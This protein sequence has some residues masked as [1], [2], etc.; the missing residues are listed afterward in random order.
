MSKIVPL[1]LLL[2][3][4]ASCSENQEEQKKKVPPFE[5][6]NI[7]VSEKMKLAMNPDYLDQIGISKTAQPFLQEYYK[8][9]NYQ[10]RWIDE[11]ALTANGVKMKNLMDSAI[12]IGIPDGRAFKLNI[13]NYIQEELFITASLSRSVS[14]LQN[15]MID[16][17][18]TTAK[19]K[20]FAAAN[21]FDKITNFDFSKDLKH[22]FIQYG[23]NDSTYI[24]LAKG[25][26][27]IADTLPID[28]TRFEIKPYKID[29]ARSFNMMREALVS[30]GYLA[31]SVTDSLGIVDRLKRFQ[32]DNALDTDGK[33]GSNTC[34][35]LNESTYDKMERIILVMDKI[36]SKAPYPKKYLRINIPEYK[37]RYFEDDTLRT[38]HNIVVGKYENQTPELRSSLRRI[39]VYPNWNVPYSISTREILPAVK[40]SV[41][42]LA[43]HDYKVYRGNKEVDPH[44]VNWKQYGINS[45][46]FRIVQ[47]PGPKNSLGIIKFDFHNEHSVYFHD[48]PAKSLFSLPVRAFSHGCMRTHRPVALA[49]T[50]LHY[51]SLSP[52]RFN[53]FRPDSLD[54]IYALPDSLMHENFNREVKLFDP[55]PIFIEYESVSRE[56]EKMILHI[57]IYGRDEEFLRVFNE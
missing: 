45:F 30:K 7:P 6:R 4:I 50:I 15:G 52:R 38:E 2:F 51:D 48:T 19:M 33:V 35:A 3:L 29:S 41:S 57:D 13:Q 56:G 36:R 21:N 10:P 40:R 49:D 20:K 44:T 34:R 14:D 28:R 54:S 39:I 12:V 31:D 53:K 11:K 32:Y 25:L 42:Y 43:K 55:I 27:Y 16:F 37:L 23:P 9:R 5:N 24:V 47:Q 22:Q 8:S 18:D 46:P 26:I 17:S 1:L